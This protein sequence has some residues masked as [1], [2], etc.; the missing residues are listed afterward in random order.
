MKRIFLALM[1]LFIM[2]S[3]AC[4]DVEISAANFPDNIFRA[5][6]RETCDDNND[7]ILTN[8][9]LE[10]PAWFDVSGQG[11]S[12]LKGIEFFTGLNGLNCA[13]NNL[14]GTLDLS[15]NTALTWLNCSYNKLE[16]LN[17]T[18]CMNLEYIYCSN[19]QL[20]GTLDLSGRTALKEAYFNNNQLTGTVNVRGC[21]GLTHLNL[22]T[23]KL[24]GTLDL[25]SN[26]E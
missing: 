11:I 15:S 22:D 8:E 23:N 13:N 9:D 2:V 10:Y 1:M 16:S 12:S 5:Y 21:T 19:N 14:T 26:P 6:V 25:S 7:G 3:C 18:G 24:T 17:I 20:T 4:A